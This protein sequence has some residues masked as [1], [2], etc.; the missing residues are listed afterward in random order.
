MPADM[1]ALSLKQAFHDFTDLILSLSDKQFLSSLDGWSPR[2]VV[3]HLIGWNTLM[4][5]A[6]RSILAG[7]PPSYYQDA[8]NDFSHINAG[9][10]AEY[11]SRSRRE[12]LTQLESSMEKLEA[13]LS[14]LPAEELAADHGVIHHGGDPATVKRIIHSLTG[15]YRYHNHQI[16]EWLET[17][18]E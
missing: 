1:E 17:F 11:S 12:L 10:V 5:E 14:G 13:F 8:P 15:D 16:I 7:T 18:Q 3:A 9:F 4:I 2:D 6:S